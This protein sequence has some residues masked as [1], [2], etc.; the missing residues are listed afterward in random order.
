[1]SLDFSSIIAIN[2]TLKKNLQKILKACDDYINCL[3][4]LNNNCY[5]KQSLSYINTFNT[6]ESQDIA[7]RTLLYIS[8]INSLNVYIYK[9]V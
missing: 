3:D 6:L 7:C 1:M 8:I 2:L 9:S 5:F 4:N